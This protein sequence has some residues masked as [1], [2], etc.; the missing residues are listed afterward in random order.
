MAVITGVQPQKTSGGFFRAWPWIGFTPKPAE[1]N[2]KRSPRPVNPTIP[3]AETTGTAFVCMKTSHSARHGGTGSGVNRRDW[4]NGRT[5][6][7]TIDCR[8]I[9]PCVRARRPKS[10][11][12]GPKRIDPYCADKLDHHHGL[13]GDMASIPQ[14]VRKS[15]LGCVK[16]LKCLKKRTGRGAII[17]A[18]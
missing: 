6:V 1:R 17:G 16:N 14:D 7:S 11:E 15:Q 13:L 10:D 2:S 9:G 5:E 12:T 3:N 4:P 8:V 18:C